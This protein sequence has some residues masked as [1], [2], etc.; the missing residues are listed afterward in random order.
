MLHLGEHG[1]AGDWREAG[2]DDT[3]GLATGVD[4]DGGDHVAEAHGSGEERV[5]WT[6]GSY[7]GTRERCDRGLTP[8]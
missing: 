1:V 5:E 7:P 4:V 6:P 8:T 3:A 2:G